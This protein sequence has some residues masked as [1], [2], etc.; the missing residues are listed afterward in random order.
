MQ[1]YLLPNHLQL[2]Y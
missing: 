1:E 2:V